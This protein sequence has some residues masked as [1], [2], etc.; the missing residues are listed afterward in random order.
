MKKNYIVYDI[1][2]Q[3]MPNEI[4]GGWNNP[5][6]MK[7]SS[8]VTYSYNE[9]AYRFWGSTEEEHKKLLKY[10]HGS[11]LIGFNIIHFDSRVL[12]G[13]DRSLTPEGITS[14]EPFGETITVHNFDIYAEI[15][16]AFYDTDDV[17][18]AL[19]QQN[20][21]KRTHVKGVWDLDSIAKNT[22]GGNCVKLAN[23]K[24]APEK[25]KKGMIK[26]LM[27]YNLQ[28][29]RVEKELFEFVRTKK[30]IVNGNYDIVKMRL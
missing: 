16:K 3:N 10:V 28:D 21:D 12:L 25:F 23:G 11:T 6:G 27:E 18:S 7:I 13:N 9:N 14:G 29:V 24:T 1:E 2:T 4:E 19:E 17:A 15:W 22:L 8:C 20:K 26:E 30:Y 5:F